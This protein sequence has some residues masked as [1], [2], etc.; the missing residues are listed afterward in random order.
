MS[1]F[2]IAQF[3]VAVMKMPLASPPMLDFVDAL[4]RINALAEQAPGFVWRLQTADGDAT[5][6]RPMGENVLVNLSVWTDADA[7]G[8]YVYQSAHAEIMRRRSEWFERM[9]EA[10]SVL[11]WV[12][13]GYRPALSEAIDRLD[14]LRRLGATAEAFSF[15]KPFPH[16]VAAPAG[17]QG[18]A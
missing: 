5:A 3:N 14:R 7:L 10:Y 13:G 18:E 8:A 4:D 1:P 2:Q 6:L 11:W 16:P 9:A 15:R 17:E 12:P